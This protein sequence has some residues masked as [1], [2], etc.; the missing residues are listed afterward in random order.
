MQQPITIL[1]NHDSESKKTPN[2]I[3]VD[4]HTGVNYNYNNQTRN[5]DNIKI[6]GM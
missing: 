3:V 1:I 6:K 2:L 5:P 4:S